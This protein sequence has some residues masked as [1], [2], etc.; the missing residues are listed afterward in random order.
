MQGGAWAERAVKAMNVVF[1][2]DIQ[3]SDWAD[4]DRLVPQAITASWLVEN[5]GLQC[6]EAAM[7]L[8]QAGCYLHHRG[9]F[10][11]AEPLYRKAIAV[12]RQVLGE[13]HPNFAI[14]LNNLAELCDATG[15]YQEAEPLYR[16]STEICRKC[17]AS[18]THSFLPAST[19]CSVVPC[20]GPL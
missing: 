9:Q 17:W 6:K 10:G 14:G 16:R 12:F 7:L 5:F 18:S 2:G 20:N 4:C 8:N 13:Q 15:R 3:I 11:L 19:T 1:P